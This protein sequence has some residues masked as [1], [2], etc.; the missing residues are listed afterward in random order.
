MY[1][2]HFPNV[3]KEC[4]N[5]KKAMTLKSLTEGLYNPKDIGLDLDDTSPE[6]VNRVYDYIENTFKSHVSQ[7]MAAELILK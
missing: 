1:D 3:I 6:N 5:N 7:F 4:K 2:L